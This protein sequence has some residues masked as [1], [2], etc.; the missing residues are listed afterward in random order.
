MKTLLSTLVALSML[1]VPSAAIAGAGNFAL[2]NKTGAA[3]T[4]LS[5]RRSGT[6]AWSP[7]GGSAG[8]GARVSISFQD[9]DCAF[10]IQA[11]LADGQVAI[12]SGVNLCDVSTVTLNRSASGNQWVD[13][14]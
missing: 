7:L 4:A 14:D 3:I 9:P 2:V 13:Y 8:N 11:K 12:F 6:A 5:V 1:A 10:D